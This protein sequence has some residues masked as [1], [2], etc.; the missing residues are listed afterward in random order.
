MIGQLIGP[1]DPC[2]YAIGFVTWQTIDV[3]AGARPRDD[4]MPGARDPLPTG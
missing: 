4:L 2:R 3:Y 1:S